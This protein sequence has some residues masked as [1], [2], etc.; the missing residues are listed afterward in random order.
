[1]RLARACIIIFLFAAP[2][3]ATI[4]GTVRGTVTDAQRRP[5]PDIT[6]HLTS[7]TSQWHVATKTDSGGAFVF[8]GVPLGS[9]AV[10]S[11]DI[12]LTSGTVVTVNLTMPIVAASM[13]VTA[14]ATPIDTRSPTTQTTIHRIDVQRAPGADRTNSLSMITDFVPSAVIVHDQLHVRGGH[15]VDWLIDGIPVPNTNIASN[16]GP[17]FDP[18]DVE[19]LETQRGGYSAE[20]GDRTYAVFNVVPRSGFE[21]NSEAHVLLNYGSHR[22]TDDQINFGGHSDRFAYYASASGNRTDAGLETPEPAIVHDGAQGAGGFASL[23]LLPTD[24]DQ[25]RVVASARADRYEVPDGEDIEREHDVFL[26]TSWL[27]TVSSTSLLTVAPFFHVTG[28]NFDGSLARDHRTSRYAGAEATYAITLQKN[29]FRS[30]AFGFHQQD[31]A[32]LAVESVSQSDKPSGS[33]VAAFIEDRYDLTDR[34][35]IRGGI[36]VTQFRGGIHESAATPRFGVTFRVTSHAIL[37]ASYSDVY[38]APPLSTASGP[39]LEFAADQGFGFLPLHGERDHQA[40]IGLSVPAAGWNFDIAAFR[41]NARNFFD[42]DALGN[43]NV[44]FPLTIDRVFIRGAELMAQRGH[45]HVAFSHQTVEGEGGVTGGLTDFSPPEEGRFFLDHDQRNTLSAGA[46]LQ[47]PREAWIS[48]N[49]SYGSGF[50]QGDGPQHLPGH[51]TL[52]LASAIP[53]GRWTLKLTATNV[54]NK[55]YLLDESNTFGGTHW[56]DSRVVMAQV[57]YRFHY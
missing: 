45:F 16:V 12:E 32:R 1:M 35:T 19:T 27:R 8:Q 2:L 18:R 24:S 17:Q 39:L 49:V 41:T 15:Q 33:V 42:H 9:Y 23:I 4:F 6:V 38:Q 55:R 22:T 50:L 48:G 53:L 56:N 11:T 30:G 31:D 3:S 5:V 21:R 26:N 44:F 40:E 20:Y 51:T 28:T 25:V 10:E 14:A 57:E 46:T 29:D 47:L 43:S 54:T 36:R 34:L 37:R 13:E 52:D 7:R